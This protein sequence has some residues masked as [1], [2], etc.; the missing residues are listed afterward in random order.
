MRRNGSDLEA[1]VVLAEWDAIRERVAEQYNARSAAFE[2]DW[3]VSKHGNP[4]IQQER[5]E[6]IADGCEIKDRSVLDV[7]CGLGEFADYLEKTDSEHSGYAGIDIASGM[8]ERAQL[9]R[10][11]LSLRRMDIM[12]EF[13][14]RADVVV[15]IAGFIISGQYTETVMKAMVRCLWEKVTRETLAFTVKNDLPMRPDAF[16]EYCETLAPRVVLVEG[17][18]AAGEYALFMYRDTA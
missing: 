5:F 8:I 7:G 14:E 16:R 2:E 18:G 9:R 1:P 4:Q 13:P 10:P 12:R 3:Q 15:M 11:D 6:I 17:P